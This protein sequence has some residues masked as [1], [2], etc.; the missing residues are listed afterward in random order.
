MQTNI[1]PIDITKEMES[2][3]LDYAMSVIVSRALPDVRDGLK[4]VHR[5]ILYSMYESGFFYNK[6]YRKCARVIGDVMG[7]YH[8]HGDQTIYS[9]LVRM[10]QE[11][12]LLTPLIDGQGNFG[13][14]DGDNAAA[15]RYTECRLEKITEIALLKDIDKNTVDFQDNY[16][17]T[18][19]EPQILPAMLPNLLINGSGG[20]AVG[21]ATN[22]PPHNPYAVIESCIQY[23]DNPEITIEELIQII[24]APDFPTRGLILQSSNLNEAY[25]TGRGTIIMRGRAEIVE[26]N[27]RQSIIITEIPYMVNKASMMEKIASLVKEKRIEGIS[28]LRDESDMDGIRVVVEIKRDAMADLVLRQLYSYTQLQTSFGINMVALNKGMPRLMNLQEIISSFIDFRKE[29]I[30]R[31]TVYLLEQVRSKAIT[32][33][34]LYIAVNNIEKTVAIIKSA[35]DSK[36]AEKELM[37]IKWDSTD[38]KPYFEMLEITDFIEDKYCYLMHEQARAILEMRLLRLTT[39]EKDKI[40][41]ELNKLVERMKEYRSIIEYKTKLLA[42][43]KEELIDLKSNFSEKRLTE[44]SNQPLNQDDEELIAKEEMVV[45]VTN[46][47][48]IKRVPLDLY[49]SQKRGGKGRSAASMN[50]D[51]FINKIFIAHTLTPMLFFSNLGRVYQIKLYRLPL[52]NPQNKGRP[53]VNLLNLS[54][55]EKITNILAVPEEVEEKQIVFATSLGKIK[56]NELSSF[57]YIPSNGKIAIKL[58]EKDKLISV[59]ICD[60]NDHIFLATKKGKAIRFALNTIRCIKARDAAG[61]K[62]MKITDDDKL[63]SM[64]VLL[65]NNYTIEERQAY[66]SLSVSYRNLLKEPQQHLDIASEL[67]EG[68]DLKLATKMVQE[69][70]LLLSVTENGFGKSTS[71]YEYRK[72]NRGG[73]GV[74][75]FAVSKKTGKVVSVMPITLSDE[76]MLITNKGQAI[77]CPLSNLRSLSR[78][79]RGVTLFKTDGKEKVISA[80]IIEDVKTEEKNSL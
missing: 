7:K 61:V 49:R 63:I 8:P 46:S 31:R 36:T 78:N 76:I 80:A 39:T 18:E 19:I 64:T 72:A 20:I 67:P 11:F 34:G 2:S 14:I 27:N 10:V 15:M 12:S 38:V 6:Q 55:K 68:L 41:E 3:Y 79:T 62:G 47:G 33:L 37:D 40:L 29:V 75:N 30:Y 24:Q 58:E 1:L 42:L 50:D 48:Y 77:R 71:S 66:F 32:I 57:K 13:S 43:M 17:S 9:S 69:E 51:D 56:R 28:D 54:D 74:I 59:R 25:R 52:G 4:P 5:R 70:Q 35:Q 53:L 16:D 22:I 73:M 45:T 60:E 44:I 21:M 65:G 26:T 23:I